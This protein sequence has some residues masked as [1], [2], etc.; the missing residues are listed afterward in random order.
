MREH[1]RVD[2]NRVGFLGT[3]EGGWT[4]P[5]I[6]RMDGN[7]AFLV[8]LCGGGL[9]KGDVAPQAPVALAR[10]G[11]EGGRARTSAGR[12]ARNRCRQCR[13]CRGRHCQRLRPAHQLRPGAGLETLRRCGA[14]RD[15]HRRRLTRHGALREFVGRRYDRIEEF[16]LGGQG[17]PQSARRHVS[18]H[19]GGYPAVSRAA[20]CA[21]GPGFWPLLV[22][23][24][25]QRK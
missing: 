21:D 18:G 23:W 17:L 1:E 19:G 3:S 10:G 12:E 6:A 20:R 14:G 16:G 4:A 8:A 24:L 15:R 9:T 13:A 25:E 5:L 22:E 2:A 7:V 11:P